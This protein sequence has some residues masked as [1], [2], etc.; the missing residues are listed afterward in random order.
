MDWKEILFWVIIVIVALTVALGP[1]VLRH[2]H[3]DYKQQT[4]FRTITER[5]TYERWDDKT[6]VMSETRER[7]K[8]ADWEHVEKHPK[9]KP[10]PSEKVRS[11]MGE[12]DFLVVIVT[13]A[14]TLMTFFLIAATVWG[15]GQIL[16]GLAV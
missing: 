14:L 16:G 8:N 13:A 5:E 3:R 12:V 9:G 7:V 15:I 6:P 10:S 4:T 11:M 2:M 1:E